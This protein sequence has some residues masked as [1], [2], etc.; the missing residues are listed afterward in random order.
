MLV[1]LRR[2]ATRLFLPGPQLSAIVLTALVIDS[3][4]V[5]CVALAALAD[6]RPFGW[7][8]SIRHGRIIPIH[9]PH[10]SPSAAQGYCELRGQGPIG[11]ACLPVNGLIL[12]GFSTNVVVATN[13]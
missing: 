3:R 8:R 5:T 7:M 9:Q 1:S 2:D 12:W 6:Q 11:V 13:G 10:G 4:W